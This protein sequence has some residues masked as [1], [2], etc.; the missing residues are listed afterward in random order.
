M[1]DPYPPRSSAP[2]QAVTLMAGVTRALKRAVLSQLHPRMLF[3][4]LLPFL[5][6]LLGAIVLVWLFWDPLTGW[7]EREV[8][9]WSM[10]ERADQWLV[11]VGIASLKLWLIPIAAVI[12]LLPVSGLLGL[13]IAALCVMPMV[14]GHLEH[15]DYAGLGRQGRHALAAGL[16]NAAWVSA[17]FAAGWLLTLPLWLIPPMALLLSVFWW[18]FAF[19]RMM[20]V[21]A[22][23]EHASPAERRVLDRRHNAG[24]WLLGFILALINLLPPAWLVLPV[25]SALVYAHYGLDALQRL[26]R[27]T[28]IEA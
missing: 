14:I 17:A 24:F 1:T 28:V 21:D 18:A 5:I 27:E 22:L 16:W 13:V 11:A 26:R 9:G 8:A 23:V 25:F 15:R 20:R 7:L 19:S 2:A 12:I 4:L 10:V 6:T 3:A